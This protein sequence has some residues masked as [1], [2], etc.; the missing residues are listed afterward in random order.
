[1]QSVHWTEPG[2]TL[3]QKTTITL[4]FVINS[5]DKLMESIP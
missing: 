4:L 3:E 5:Q 2:K 1:M